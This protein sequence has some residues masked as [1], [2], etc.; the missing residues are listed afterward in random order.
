MTL[1]NWIFGT[2]VLLAVFGLSATLIANPFGL[3]QNIFHYSTNC[4][5]N[6]WY[7]SAVPSKKDWKRRTSKVYA[8]STAVKNADAEKETHV[9][10]AKARNKPL[11]K[12]K[13]VHLTVIEG[14]R[15]KR[16]KKQPSNPL[17]L[18]CPFF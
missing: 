15:E 10:R 1:R 2:I 17:K 3:L 4:W 13:H 18:I 9:P 5:C 7:L 16:T 11:R 12:R 8:S 6:L 14:K